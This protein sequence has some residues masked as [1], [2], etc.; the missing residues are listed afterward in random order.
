MK[1]AYLKTRSL[2]QNFSRAGIVL[3]FSDV[4]TLRRC[5]LILQRWSEKQCGD[6]NSFC[7]FSIERDETTGKP[8]WC[9]YPHD[10]NKVRRTPIADREAGALRRV[11]AICKKA[12]LVYYHQGDPRGCSLYVGTVEMLGGGAIDS[13]YN[14]L[15]A[16]CN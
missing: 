1:T 13:C 11:A 9:V 15:I 16:C 8:F 4:N 5:E 3:S 6:S 14:R 7:S 10:S 2:A 12:G